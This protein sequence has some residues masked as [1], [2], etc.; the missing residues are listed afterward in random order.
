MIL[1]PKR[2]AA[3]SA[4]LP[5]TWFRTGE[6]ASVNR[7]DSDLGGDPA[8]RR[9]LMKHAERI[10]TCI[11]R[12]GAAVAQKADATIATLVSDLETLVVKGSSLRLTRRHGCV[13][14]ELARTWWRS[15]LPS[16][17]RRRREVADEIMLGA[18]WILRNLYADRQ[19]AGGHPLDPGRHAQHVVDVDPAVPLELER[20]GSARAVGTPLDP[21]L[22][23]RVQRIVRSKGRTVDEALRELGLPSTAR[24]QDTPSPEA[25]AVMTRIRRP[26]ARSDWDPLRIRVWWQGF[27]RYLG[28]SY[29]V[30]LVQSPA[31]RQENAPPGRGRDGTA[32]L[33]SY[34]S[35]QGRFIRAL[36]KEP[37]GSWVS[38]VKL[39][40]DAGIK[41]MKGD[42]WKW[43]DDLERRG[44]TSP[45]YGAIVR[46]K[47]R[48]VSVCLLRV[49]GGTPPF[50]K[51]GLGWD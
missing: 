31:T 39:R 18:E 12:L 38:I 34:N 32:E 23:Q 13:H 1:P 37:R 21:E 33:D 6:T 45:K 4:T 40:R 50:W 11:E 46:G 16:R 48:R 8:A 42:I 30:L 36:L 7:L 49:P 51:R 15:P 22:A 9:G 20:L 5:L 41:F 2:N 27:I 29:G 26:E 47:A 44:V 43:L 3:S 28:S 24:L 19:R 25:A 10:V 17:A 14:W 35:S